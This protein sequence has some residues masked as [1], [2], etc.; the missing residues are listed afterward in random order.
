M[1]VFILFAPKFLEWPLAI[2]RELKSRETDIS[3]S[4]LATGDRKVFE[5]VVEN[6]DPAISP[7]DWLDDLERKW[8]ATPC[9]DTRL[10]EY[11][12]MFG[13]GAIRRLICADRQIGIGLISGGFLPRTKLMDLAEDTEVIRRYILG[14]LD[15]IFSIFTRNK[16]A[17]VFLYASASAVSVAISEA[18][19]YLGIPIARLS[20]T[21]MGNRY[22]IDSSPDGLLYPVQEI[23]ERAIHNPKIL[24]HFLPGARR[25][26]EDFR[27]NPIQLE[28][29]KYVTDR[30]LRTRSI[31]GIGRQM[32]KDL[33]GIIGSIVHNRI[34]TLRATTE[35]RLIIFHLLVGLRLQLL[36]RNGPFRDIGDLPKRPFAYFPLHVDPEASTMVLAPMHTNQIA[37]IESLAKSLPIG[38]NLVVKEHIPMLG[39]R[40]RDFYKRLAAIPSVVLASPYEES[41]TLVSKAS[42]T[43]VITGTSAWEAILLKKCALIIGNSPFLALRRG[44]IHC[45]DLSSL[46]D[47]VSKALSLSPID[48]EKLVL[49]VASLMSQ[50]FEFPKQL[51]WGEV[52]K[53]T[54]SQNSNVLINICNRLQEAIA[55]P[56]AN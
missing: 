48:D 17:L 9:D 22:V 1:K 35:W 36:E 37:V 21:R 2:A 27:A 10:A 56:T 15:Y 44:F 12:K 50:S 54:V 46:P 52:T 38:M 13:P 28:H 18:C 31:F 4:G 5:R 55:N 47:A 3:F 14:L 41:P 39:R 40:P 11:E 6:E 20:H 16:P 23:F 29:K 8:I 7:I 51:L 33:R 25:Y 32:M 42:L 34:P 49:Y 30:F 53:E 45:P 26:L 19:R 43:C 24:E